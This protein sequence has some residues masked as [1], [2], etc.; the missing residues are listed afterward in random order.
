ML[1]QSDCIDH[2]Y[3]SDGYAN[4]YSKKH[5]RN[6]GLHRL[7]LAEKLG[8]DVVDMKG[9]ALH[10]CDNKRCINPE[11]LELGTQRQNV[12][13]AIE[14]GLK[15]P[16]SGE[17]HPCTKLTDAQV[18]YVLNSTLGVRALGREL[19]VSHSIISRLRNGKARAS[20][21]MG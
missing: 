13:D 15:V 4:V 21:R 19:G 20:Q 8:V 16:K 6:F 9:V 2:G 18:D 7:V 11:H 1:K 12:N 3:G 5:K 17:A 14:R 10:T